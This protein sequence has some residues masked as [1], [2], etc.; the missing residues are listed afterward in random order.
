[1]LAIAALVAGVG[2]AQSSAIVYL[3]A[4]LLG[5]AQIAL[6]QNALVSVHAATPDELRGRVVG[7]WVMVFQASSLIGAFLA[8]IVADLLG[9]RAAM[10]AGAL[11]LGLVGLVATAAIRRADWRMAPAKAA[12][13]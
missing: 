13:A 2:L 10:L 7:I 12:G 11:A 9:V 4:F 5:G 8:G 3:F 1:M 6:G